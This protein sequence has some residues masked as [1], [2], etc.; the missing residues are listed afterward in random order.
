MEN[1]NFEHGVSFVIFKSNSMNIQLYGLDECF[2]VFFFVFVKREPARQ[3]NE[4]RGRRT[5][6]KQATLAHNADSVRINAMLVARDIC[7]K[8]TQSKQFSA[9][10]KISIL[11][12]QILIWTE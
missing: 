8:T 12:N 10:G 4:K 1:N 9:R 6:V 2:E 3:Q 11:F 7:A 5:T